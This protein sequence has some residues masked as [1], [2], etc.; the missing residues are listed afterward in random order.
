MAS[1]TFMTIYLSMVARCYKKYH[2]CYWKYWAKWV[3]VSDNWLWE[4][5]FENFKNDMYEAYIDHKKNH[6]TTQI[7]KDIWSERLWIFPHIYSKETC[8]F[9]TSQE[10]NIH[11][12]STNRILYKWKIYSMTELSIFLDI[13]RTSLSFFIKHWK[14]IEEIISHYNKKYART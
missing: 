7:D 8:C 12:E 4:K 2:S 11:R 1:T 10:N 6:K 3:T 9:L 14:S 13:P 5:W